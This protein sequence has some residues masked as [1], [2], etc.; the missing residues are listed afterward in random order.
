MGLITEDR[1]GSGRE[2]VGLGRRTRMDN[3]DAEITLGMRSL[4]GIFFGLVLI[5]GIFFG[6]GYSVGRSGGARVAAT[7]DNSGSNAAAS[8]NLKK[9]SADQGLTP[10]LEPAQ[11]TADST[12]TPPATDQAAAPAPAA[13]TASAP[14]AAS[15]PVPA[16]PRPAVASTQPAMTPAPVP[17]RPQVAVAQT[18]ASPAPQVQTVAATVPPS[19]FMVQIAA[20]RLQEDAT[21]L[22][23]A[24]ERRGYHVVVRNE[25]TDALLHVQVGPFSSRIDAYNM[26]A[27]LLADGYNA[28]VK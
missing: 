26:R 3:E 24:L 6:L 20:V 1:G 16:A 7:T 27:K 21:V 18:A 5:C 22:V 17:A 11:T 8:S 19:S 13:T 23:N 14:L 25:P 12:Q 4:L 2:P 9:P 28:V 10:A 15:T